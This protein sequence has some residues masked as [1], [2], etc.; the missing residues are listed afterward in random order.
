MVERSGAFGIKDT[1]AP[2]IMLEFEPTLFDI[3]V[4]R[5][6]QRPQLAAVSAHIPRARPAKHSIYGSCTA[7]SRLAFAVRCKEREAWI[8]M[9]I[10]VVLRLWK[11][12]R[13]ASQ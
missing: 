12:R 4:G 7:Q 8:W 11:A 2:A 6:V 3:D 5:T 13:G 10:K 1:I 9:H